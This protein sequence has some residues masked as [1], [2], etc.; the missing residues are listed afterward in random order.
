M[1]RITVKELHNK[2]RQKKILFLTALFA[3]IF[4]AGA[5]FEFNITMT[6]KEES[7]TNEYLTEWTEQNA[8]MIQLKLDRYYDVLEY[9]AQNIRNMPFDSKET[10]EYLEDNFSRKSTDFEYFRILDGEGLAVNVNRDYSQEEYFQTAITGGKGFAMNGMNYDDGVLLSVPIYNDED[11][12]E[13][14]L[15]GVLFGSRLDIFRKTGRLGKESDLYLTDGNGNYIVK[16]EKYNH[17]GSN[18]FTDLESKDLSL[19][20]STIEFRVR[21]GISVPFEIH[22]NSSEGRVIVMSPVKGTGLYTATV[23]SAKT[24]RKSSR[25]YQLYV[26]VLT[27]KIIGVLAV[28]AGIYLYFQKE[29]RRYIRNLNNQLMMNEETYRITARTNDTCVFTYDVSTEQ[30]QFLNDKYKD[31]GLEQ[32]QLSI[33]VLLK[34]VK[35]INPEACM[36]IREILETIDE[37]KESHVQKMKLRSGG[38]IRYLKVLAT[39][40]FDDHGN[41]SRMVGSIEDVTKSENDQQRL[42]KEEGFRNTLLSDSLGYM[43]VDVDRDHIVESTP[44]ILKGN[45]PRDYSYTEVFSYFLSKRVKTEH[46]NELKD[47]MSCQALRQLFEEKTET[48]TYEYLTVDCEGEDVWFSCEIHL[49]EDSAHNLTAYLVYRNINDVKKQQENLEKRASTD[50][51]TGAWNRA[52]GTAQI[53]K[54]ME[55]VPDEGCV[56]AF[57]I[58]DLDN[59]K[60]LN[61][62]LGHMWGDKALYEVAAIMKDHC[63]ARQDVVCRLGGD[64]FVVFMR[65]IPQEAVERNI[66][67]LSR[68]LHITYEKG[69]LSVTISA[70]MGIAMT[71]KKGCKFKELYEEADSCLYQ[72]KRTFK[73]SYHI[74]DKIV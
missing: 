22:G 41:V 39:N 59:F 31:L 7:A 40:I 65:N 11:E 44:A 15:C 26:I 62:V 20:L 70:S 53:E 48:K 35:E 60:K 28:L 49:R 38:K 47:L 45:D 4:I 12:A 8:R 3:V 17:A 43:I 69:L 68:K 2:K 42:Q 73:G 74:S 36:A 19:V 14:V 63:R 50:L 33:P 58:A 27:V 52:A 34:K 55:E 30:I 21:S 32:A 64:E 23:I 67:A 56:H 72:V 57:A 66:D 25:S 37:K 9:A 5:L 54:I 71:T 46:W 61:D 13:G 10:Q 24:A 6:G 51:L 1:G 18:I 29:D 16:R